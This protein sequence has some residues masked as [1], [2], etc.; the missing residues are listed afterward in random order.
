M[1]VS[2]PLTGCITRPV[3]LPPGERITELQTD[4]PH[5]ADFWNQ[6]ATAHVTHP[7]YDALWRA[8]EQA[9]RDLLFTIDRRDYRNGLLMTDPMVSGQW[10][11]PW[12]AD[13]VTARHR[14]ESSLMTVRR[15]LRFEFTRTDDGRFGVVPKVLVEQ[16]AIAERRI[17]SVVSPRG[18][19]GR[20]TAW[21]NPQT[22]RGVHLP[23]RYW[24]A[25]ARDEA[26][27]QRVARL[28]ESRL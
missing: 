11:E 24:F 6:P 26:L 13:V 19:F 28:I 7:D 15:T 21:G 17:S 12:R 8:A 5:P 14:L 23:R 20:T 22:D 16:E 2:L 25:I 27:E 1:T 10:F 4:P 9:A 18:A 3:Q